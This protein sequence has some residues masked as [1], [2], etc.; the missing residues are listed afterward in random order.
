M[1]ELAEVN[2]RRAEKWSQAI[3]HLIKEMWVEER[4]EREKVA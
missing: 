4:V 2:Q 1:R 3:L